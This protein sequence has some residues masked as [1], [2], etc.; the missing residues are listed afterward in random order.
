MLLP[1]ARTASTCLRAVPCAA[2]PHETVNS[3]APLC[4][5]AR[6]V[7]AHFVLFRR[8]LSRIVG[9]SVVLPVGVFNILPLPRRT[10]LTL[11]MGKPIVPPAW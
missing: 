4:T 9:V 3:A 5:V 1:L 6:C 7:L 11:V 8:R 10:P 2:S